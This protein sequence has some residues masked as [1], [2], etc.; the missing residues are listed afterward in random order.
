MTSMRWPEPILPYES[1][2]LWWPDPRPDRCE[3]GIEGMIMSL[4]ASA[5]RPQKKTKQLNPENRVVLGCLMIVAILVLVGCCVLEMLS[6]GIELI[7]AR[8]RRQWTGTNKTLHM[9]GSDHSNAHE[10]G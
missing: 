2:T 6:I 8:L 1:Y 7:R 4:I 3:P 9:R 5:T 10:R